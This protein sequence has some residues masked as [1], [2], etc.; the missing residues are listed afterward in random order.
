MAYPTSCSP[1][2]WSSATPVHLV[3]TLLR[4]DPD[5][6][7]GRVYMAPAVPD[8]MLPLSVEGLPANGSEITLRVDEH[9][10]DVEGLP[11]HL[12]LVREPRPLPA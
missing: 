3:R 6:P 9:G 8:A 12:Q 11:P 5:V 4:Y 1:Q 2:A 7:A 10:W